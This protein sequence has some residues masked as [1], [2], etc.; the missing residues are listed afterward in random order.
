MPAESIDVVFDKASVICEGVSV[1]D[2]FISVLEIF[3]KVLLWLMGLSLFP[4]VT[5]TY[6]GAPYS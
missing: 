1:Q 6:D 3:I 4:Y 5:Q 2:R